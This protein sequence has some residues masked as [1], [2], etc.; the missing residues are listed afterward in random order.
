M[1][2]IPGRT[3]KQQDRVKHRKERCLR[4]GRLQHHSPLLAREN[5]KNLSAC[6]VANQNT[7]GKPTTR[8]RDRLPLW[9]PPR[10]LR[11]LCYHHSKVPP[12][13]P[14]VRNRQ[15]QQCMPP[16]LVTA[17]TTRLWDPPKH[18]LEACPHLAHQ[19]DLCILQVKRNPRGPLIRRRV[20]QPCTPHLGRL[21]PT[22]P[23]P[24]GHGPRWTI[25]PL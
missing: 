15:F 10:H 19:R 6:Q 22:V 24:E 4:L 3:T 17:N 21:E 12:R 7:I 1:T 8:P 18:R 23:A 16:Q 13:N 9:G 25:L 11:D 20:F 5:P 2:S 14:L